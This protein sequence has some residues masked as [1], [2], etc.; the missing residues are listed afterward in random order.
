M[1]CTKSDT[2]RKVLEVHKSGQWSFGVPSKG[3]I[4]AWKLVM[5]MDRGCDCIYTSVAISKLSVLDSRN[6]YLTVLK[7]RG[8]R[9]RCWHVWFL[10]RLLFLMT[11]I[12]QMA[13]CSLCLPMAFPLYMHL[14]YPFV[15]PN[16]FLL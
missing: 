11:A 1:W 13:S 7:V 15:C 16:L 8:P 12:L 3:S 5:G 6:L 9:S 2:L 4:L 14:W 10:L